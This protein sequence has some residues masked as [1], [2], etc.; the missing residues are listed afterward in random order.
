MVNRM[1]RLMSPID[2]QLE[3]TA[4]CNQKCRHCYNYW[5]HS[6]A[7]RSVELSSEDLGCILRKL[8]EAKVVQLTFTG[9]EPLL[10]PDILMS[11]MFEAHKLGMG[12]GLNSNATLITDEIARG[13]G[14]SGLQHALISVLGPPAIHNMLGGGAEIPL[15]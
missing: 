13:L 8:A 2:V 15:K 9:G 1:K 11:S 6:D 10:H 12:F 3:I 5:R 14:S 7:P 4:L